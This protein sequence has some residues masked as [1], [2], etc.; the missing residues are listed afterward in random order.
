MHKKYLVFYYKQNKQ[1]Y[2]NRLSH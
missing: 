2:I 1:Q